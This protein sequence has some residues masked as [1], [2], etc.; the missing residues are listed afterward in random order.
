MQIRNFDLVAEAELQA[1]HALF[2]T[3]QFT[4]GRQAVVINGRRL[5]G[6][7][8]KVATLGGVQCEGPTLAPISQNTDPGGIESIHF[9]ESGSLV[10]SV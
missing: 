5:K 10:I 7:N 8:F 2:E 4:V 9:R 1:S 3:V 6:P